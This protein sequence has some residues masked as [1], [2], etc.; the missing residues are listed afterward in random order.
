MAKVGDLYLST[1]DLTLRVEDTAAQYGLSEEADPDT[2]ADMQAWVL[3]N[4]I[5]SKVALLTAAGLG[6]S[7]TDDELQTEVSSVVQDYF[8]GDQAAFDS[9]LDERGVTMADFTQQVKEGLITQKVYEAL[10]KDVAAITSDQA[11]A[12]YEKNKD[13][14]YTEESRATRHIL[15]AAGDSQ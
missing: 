15:I 10:T 2:Y 7:L 8:D 13:S 14:F 6:V 11:A 5:Q 3:E 4:F 1:K 9:Y 12:Y